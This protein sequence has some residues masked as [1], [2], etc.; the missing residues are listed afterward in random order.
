GEGLPTEVVAEYRRAHSIPERLLAMTLAAARPN[1]LRR[2]L[3]GADVVH[4][5]LTIALPPVRVP[6]VV[7]LYDVQHLDLPQMFS[8]AERAFR[9]FAYDRSARAAARVVVSSEFVRARAVERL[10]LETGRIR[11]IPFGIDHVRFRPGDEH[12]EPVLLY[13][14]RAW[15]HKN[16]ERLLH[17]FGLLRRVRPDLRLVLTGGG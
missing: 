5:P 14:A 2:H 12:R 3:E 4:Y 17:A 7:T 16:H 10:G 1:A 13:P 9:S 11:V 6:T 8:R 15:P